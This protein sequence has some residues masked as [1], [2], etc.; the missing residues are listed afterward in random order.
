VPEPLRRLKQREIMFQETKR[1]DKRCWFNPPFASMI[2]K[3]FDFGNSEKKHK[4]S[5]QQLIM[6]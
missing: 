4:N 2:R 6:H 3:P 5:S 1:T